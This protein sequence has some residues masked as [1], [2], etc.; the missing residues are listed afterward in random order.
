MYDI[1]GNQGSL[2][3]AINSLEISRTRVEMQ[4]LVDA[5]IK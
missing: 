1:L 3:V 4:S 2:E 5:Q